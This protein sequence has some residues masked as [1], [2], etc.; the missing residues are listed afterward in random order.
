M[1]LSVH[2]TFGAALAS[3]V[4]SHPVAGFTLGFVSHFVL[5]AIPHK[6]YELISLERRTDD[7]LKVIDLLH[8]KISLVRDILL[9]TLDVVVGFLLAFMFFFNPNHPYIFFMGAFAALI[10]DGLT[11]IYIIFRHKALGHFFDF[12]TDVIH[13]KIQV[14]QVLGILLQFFTIGILI[15]ILEVLKKYYFIN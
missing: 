12:H 10:P 6:D 7:K 1:I 5:D 2:A 3:L 15:V 11:F 9:V 8:K 14:N 13:S 4:P